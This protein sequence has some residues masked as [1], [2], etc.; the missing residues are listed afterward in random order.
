MMGDWDWD[1]DR[2][3]T[4]KTEALKLYYYVKHMSFVCLRYGCLFSVFHSIHVEGKMIASEHDICVLCW[5][6]WIESIFEINKERKKTYGSYHRI[7][8]VNESLLPSI[9]TFFWLNL[10]FGLVRFVF[11]LFILLFKKWKLNIFPLCIWS[12]HTNIHEIRHTRWEQN[13]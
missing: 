1:R 12:E 9:L 11:F 8:D 3:A 6:P 5:L 10:C 4:H 7:W 2:D 13:L